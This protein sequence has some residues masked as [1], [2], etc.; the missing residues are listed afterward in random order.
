MD[1]NAV[2]MFV[3]VVQTGSL[4]AAAQ[5]LGVP[6][7]TLSRKMRELEQQLS[8]QLLE[9]SARGTMNTRAAGSSRWSMPERPCS[10][11]RRS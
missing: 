3:N 2:E 11:R 4:S 6:L 5:R 7:P 10:V 9:R 8:V 1:L